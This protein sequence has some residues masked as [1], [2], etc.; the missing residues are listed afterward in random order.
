MAQKAQ[1]YGSHNK[2]F[3]LPEAGTI[4]VVDRKSN[5]VTEARRRGSACINPPRVSCSRRDK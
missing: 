4:K 3:L 5:K 2:T 1:E